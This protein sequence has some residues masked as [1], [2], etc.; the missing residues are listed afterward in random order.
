MD[1]SQGDPGMDF[2]GRGS[3]RRGFDRRGMR[4][5]FDRRMEFDRRQES[6]RREEFD[7]RQDFDSRFPF[8]WLL[9]F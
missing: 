9:F 3:S 6:E 1:C 5:E 8:W 4:E 2:E 7:R